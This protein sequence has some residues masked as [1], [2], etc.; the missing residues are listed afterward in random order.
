LYLTFYQNLQSCNLRRRVVVD[1]LAN[2]RFALKAAATVT[3]DALLAYVRSAL[4]IARDGR[5]AF[6]EKQ[7]VHS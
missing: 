6:C 7:S 1:A 4:N 3:A 5:L 2:G